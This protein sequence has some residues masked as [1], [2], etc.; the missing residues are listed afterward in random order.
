MK[1]AGASV[2]LFCDGAVVATG[3]ACHDRPSLG[4]GR[5]SR[6]DL[7][8]VLD[9]GHVNVAHYG[10]DQYFP[11]DVQPIW[12]REA[13]WNVER[14]ARLKRMLP[15]PEHRRILDFGCGIG[16]F[17]R[18]VTGEFA[19]VV[20]FEL[21]KRMC[22]M[23]RRAGAACFSRIEEVPVDVDTLVLFHVLEHVP[24]PWQLLRDLVERFS[25][26]D[27]V[28]LEV[29]N[30][31]EALLSLFDNPAYRRNHYSADH[32]YYFTSQTLRA[33][34][35]RAGLRVLVDDQMQR[36][37]LGNTFG[38]LAEGRGGGQNRWPTFNNPVL[39]SA[40]EQALARIGVADSIFLVCAPLGRSAS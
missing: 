13:Y 30:T 4:I 28:V 23:H 11:E 18:R 10:A 3:D 7:V 27:R 25:R 1:G 16:G 22:E 17:L 40:Y 15:R 26:V 21:S 2:C 12:E 19:G 31:G 29:P 14:I 35:E 5:C 20:G 8:Q 33:V 37:A 24:R 9:F 6:C 38:W 34:A 39:H 32:V 36:Y